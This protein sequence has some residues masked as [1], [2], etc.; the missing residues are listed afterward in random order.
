MARPLRIEYPGALWHLT[1]RG[2]EQR[3]IVQDD[4]DRRQFVELLA[5]VVTR[6][7]W[8]L[9]AWVLMT[10]HYHLVVETPETNLSR[11]MKDLDGD[12]AQ[13]FNRRWS[14]VGHLF[15]GRFGGKPIEKESYFLEVIRYVVL[16]PVRARMVDEPGDWPW[17]NYRVT[18]GLARAPEWLEVDDT[19]ERFDLRSRQTAHAKYRRFVSDAIGNPSSIWDDLQCGFYLGSKAFGEKLA[20]LVGDRKS[21]SEYPDAQRRPDRPSLEEIERAI[22][23]ALGIDQN[24]LRQGRGGDGRT[25]FAFLAR[26][27]GAIPLRQ[28]G[29][30]LGISDSGVSKLVRRGR[31]RANK[32]ERRWKL[33]IDR[34]RD[35]VRT[36]RGRQPEP[37][38]IEA[39]F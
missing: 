1:N 9:H 5:H 27:D 38:L 33:L 32:N 37:T 26:E 29:T 7:R 3:D 13:A 21:D 39:P 36:G 34:V 28:I 35:S 24:Q 12:W 20:S 8:I 2:V 22:I 25:L 17:S 6:Y 23:H 15:Q 19:L 30:T 4:L 31:D 18:A 11:G 14:R 16:N 10:N